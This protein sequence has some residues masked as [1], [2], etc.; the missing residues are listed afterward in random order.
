MIV[1]CRHW[2]TVA[3]SRSRFFLT[4]GVCVLVSMTNI[5]VGDEVYSGSQTYVYKLRICK[6][7]VGAPIHLFCGERVVFFETSE[8]CMDKC[9][10]MTISYIGISQ[11]MPVFEYKFCR[12]RPHDKCRWWAH[13]LHTFELSAVRKRF[14]LD[15]QLIFS[16]TSQHVRRRQVPARHAARSVDTCFLANFW[17]P[18]KLRLSPPTIPLH[19]VT[20]FVL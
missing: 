16:T 17:S 12:M 11:K 2:S 20:H 6:K 5:F 3:R 13:L 19:C 1:S 7:K 14:H 8:I 18:Q 9:L 10:T 4:Y 15:Q